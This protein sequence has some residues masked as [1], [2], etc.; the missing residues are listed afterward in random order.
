M[1]AIWDGNYPEGDLKMR[2]NSKKVALALAIGA[3]LISL[4]A[5]AEYQLQPAIPIDAQSENML[6]PALPIDGSGQTAQPSAPPMGQPPMGQ[7]SMGQQSDATELTGEVTV[8]NDSKTIVWQSIK[9]KKPDTCAILARK[10]ANVNISTS[11]IV[12]EGDSA[13]EQDSNFT[14][15]NAAVLANDSKVTLSGSDI[16]THGKG[17]NGIFATGSKSEIHVSEVTIETTKD[18]SRGLDAT[19]GGTINAEKVTITTKGAHCAAIATDRG[20][21]TI[22]A[23]DCKLETSGE[24]SPVIYSTGNITLNSSYG[25]ANGSE[26]AVVEGKNSISM[27]NTALFGYKLQGVMLYQSTSGDAAA[28]T[29][30]FTADRSELH[31]ESTGPVFFV[32]NTTAVANLSRT[33]VHSKGTVLA[34]VAASRWGQSGANGGDFTIN[35]VKQG[36]SGDITCDNISRVTLNLTQKSSLTGAVNPDGKALYSA[37][38]IDDSST[39]NVTKDSHVTVIKSGKA[40]FSNIKSHGHTVTYDRSQN[41]QLDGRTYNLPGGGHLIPA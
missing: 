13:S 37:V 14:G 23:E 31:N 29:A 17:A 40:D 41:P 1:R 15:R 7:P 9:T 3:C 22:T 21:G 10:K 4:P 16:T 6:P 27:R 19:F 26:M 39:W 8:E 32:T 28:G 30:T 35:A 2:S 11:N 24:G 20:E 36:L 25:V 34:N 18:S 5:E 12:K 33:D 38:S